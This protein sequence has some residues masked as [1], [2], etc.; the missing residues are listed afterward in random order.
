M[1]ALNDFTRIT[2][3]SSTWLHAC[4]A[5]RNQSRLEACV[6]RLGLGLLRAQDARLDIHLCLASLFGGLAE[7]RRFSIR[8][9]PRALEVLGR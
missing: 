6:P 1:D 2:I 9:R 8:V 4:R 3:V 7:N 5:I